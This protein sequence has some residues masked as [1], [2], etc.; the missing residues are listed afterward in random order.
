M[1]HILQTVKPFALKL[2]GLSVAAGT[3]LQILLLKK[4]TAYQMEKKK[5]NPLWQKPSGRLGNAE[6][7]ACVVVIFKPHGPAAMTDSVHAFPP[8]RRQ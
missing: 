3:P 5:K 8:E 2:R 4:E 7:A 1:A 6:I